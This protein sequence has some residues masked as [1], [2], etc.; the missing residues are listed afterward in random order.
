MKAINTSRLKNTNF[1]SVSFRILSIFSASLI[2]GILIINE[3]YALP[4]RNYYFLLLILV[5]FFITLIFSRLKVNTRIFWFISCIADGIAGLL[6][7]NGYLLSL[8]TSIFYLFTPSILILSIVQ[9]NPGKDYAMRWR[10][11][12][13]A[14]IIASSAISLSRFFYLVPYS[15]WSL[16]YIPV[17]ILFGSPLIML[18]DPAKVWK[19]S[20]QEYVTEHEKFLILKLVKKTKDPFGAKSFVY[21]G[22]GL[23]ISL[24]FW[25]ISLVVGFLG[26]FSFLDPNAMQPGVPRA[27]VYRS[28]SPVDTIISTGIEVA[29]AI[30]VL[31]FSLRYP[32]YSLLIGIISYVAFCFIWW[33]VW[34]SL[35]VSMLLWSLLGFPLFISG[36]FSII[37]GMVSILSPP[38]P[39]ELEKTG[40]PATTALAWRGWLL[41]FP[42]FFFEIVGA[43]ARG[44]F[45]RNMNYISLIVPIVI[46]PVVFTILIV[47]V[48][49]FYKFSKRFHL[50]ASWKSSFL[51]GKRVKLA[52]LGSLLVFGLTYSMA[53][54]GYHDQSTDRDDFQILFIWGGDLSSWDGESVP[55]ITHATVYSFSLD[56]ET[57]T[58]NNYLDPGDFTAYHAL[59]IKVLPAIGLTGENLYFLLKNHDGRQDTFISSL[60]ESLV[61]S[62]ADGVSVDFEML[63]TPS[64]YPEVTP[65]DWINLWERIA[66]EACKTGEYD[67]LFANY[68]N[69]GGDYSR[70]QINR[71][72]DAVDIHI[73]NMYEAHHHEGMQGSTTIVER[74]AGNFRIMYSMLN[75]KLKMEKVIPGLPLYH[76]IWINGRRAP[77]KEKEL[78]EGGRDWPFLEY[79]VLEGIMKE[80]N[81]TF[82]FDPFS[83]ATYAIFNLTLV[84]GSR[85]TCA[86]WLHDTAHLQRTIHAL[87]GYGIRGMMFWPGSQEFPDKFF[88][89]FYVA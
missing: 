84:N 1:L 46:V 37:I 32:R 28:M 34:A 85:V 4:G 50:K 26:D 74:S 47:G 44:I 49:G 2:F 17:I 43:H 22:I 82:R 86:A 76:Y 45:D 53:C 57:G 59:G 42:Y 61:Q 54:S 33:A 24:M 81:A 87:S 40:G 7:L 29:I 20:I 66:F 62:N 11:E 75:D 77:L 88:E 89:V 27:I 38:M 58:V 18:T 36:V 12:L 15:G 63:E 80:N 73:E 30:I 31:Y 71:Y 35:T 14:C 52:V 23:V 19:E 6:L 41:I 10:S 70:E 56:G 65:E 8:A 83:G 60:H 25:S 55:A 39:D 21:L 69:I 72:F 78:I 9:T 48:V 3:A 16:L 67:F 68:W 64:G 79:S 13:I 51:F 5:G